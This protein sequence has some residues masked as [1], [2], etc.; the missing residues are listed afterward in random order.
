MGCLPVPHLT[1]SSVSEASLTGSAQAAC[2]LHFSFTQLRYILRINLI[3]QVLQV[4][5]LNTA[6]VQQLEYEVVSA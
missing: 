1:S 4:G 5:L 6:R 3:T 2:E